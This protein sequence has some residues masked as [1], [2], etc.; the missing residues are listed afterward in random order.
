M[1]HND[2]LKKKKLALEKQKGLLR[3][4]NS[5]NDPAWIELMLMKEMGLVP[6]GQTKVFFTK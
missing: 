3:Q 5:Q 2:L 4:I 6:E 1:Q